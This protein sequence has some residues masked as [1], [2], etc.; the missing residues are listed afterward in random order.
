MRL[1]EFAAGLVFL[2][3]L[4]SISAAE[5]ATEVGSL[6]TEP[7]QETQTEEAELEASESSESEIVAAAELAGPAEGTTDDA[8]EQTEATVEREESQ[9][10]PPVPS[11]VPAA[12]TV[13]QSQPGSPLVDQ[14]A[15]AT[16]QLDAAAVTQAAEAVASQATASLA[17]L[18]R[19]LVAQQDRQME[20]YRETNRLITIFG[21]CFAAVGVT[22]MI[23]AAWF[24]SRSVTAL[25]GRARDSRRQLPSQPGRELLPPSNEQAPGME[26]IHASGQR[27]QG[28]MSSLERR[29]AELEEIASQDAATATP[30]G[31]PM[32]VDDGARVT[33][34]ALE[35][36]ETEHRIAQSVPRANILIRKA[37]TLI[38]MGSI[39]E[40]LDILE[41]V[42]GSETDELEL[43]LIKGQA[44]EKL[45][46]LGDALEAY[47]RA[48][49]LDTE[50]ASPLLMKAGLLNRQERFDEALMCYERALQLNRENS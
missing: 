33:G 15:E 50:N 9:P 46:R 3:S 7:N 27:F 17:M 21:I 22:A 48:E 38:Q 26:K 32:P 24:H 6:D 1:R 34:V 4:L 19:L 16:S 31:D 13:E 20:M 2:T 36:T 44:Y 40:A 47:E 28:K 45:G 18:E 5:V 41:G 25:Y 37:E 42:T 11:P 12:A 30:G 8:D 35:A 29:L 23:L 14:T 43:N 39:T 10:P 49:K